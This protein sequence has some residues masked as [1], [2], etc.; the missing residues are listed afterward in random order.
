MITC[1]LGGNTKVHLLGFCKRRVLI[2]AV[3]NFINVIA[4]YIMNLR[5]QILSKLEKFVSSVW[6]GWA[7]HIFL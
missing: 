4:V 7:L 6:F 5:V 2:D 1:D 3:E